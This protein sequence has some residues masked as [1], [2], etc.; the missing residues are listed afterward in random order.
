MGVFITD[1]RARRRVQISIDRPYDI[2][3]HGADFEVMQK[4]VPCL[5][6]T[7]V[8]ISM[9]HF[10]KLGDTFQSTEVFFT[11]SVFQVFHYA[12]DRISVGCF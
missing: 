10:V 3:K 4:G 6:D 2:I 8:R 11:C 1:G 7:A 9:A 5:R 12:I